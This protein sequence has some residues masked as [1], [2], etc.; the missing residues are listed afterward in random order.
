MFEVDLHDSVRRAPY[1]GGHARVPLPSPALHC[2]KN[3]QTVRQ[4]AKTD[5]KTSGLTYKQASGQT[6]QQ[7]Q[8]ER[9]A[10]GETSGGKTQRTED[11]S[12]RARAMAPEGGQTKAGQDRTV[13]TGQDRTR[14]DR[15]GQGRT[16]QDKTR[17]DRTGQD[18]TKTGRTGQERTRRD[19]TEHDRTSKQTDKTDQQ[20]ESQATAFSCRDPRARAKPSDR[21]TDRQTDRQEFVAVR[22]PIQRAQ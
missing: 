13:R 8:A 11:K 4:T 20:T 18:K 22:P 15:T 2:G 21:Q 7:Q 3:R 17:Q 12:P 19:K 1:S 14:Q 16:G 5:R 6:D 10:R 9:K